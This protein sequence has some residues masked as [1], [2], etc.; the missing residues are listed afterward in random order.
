MY[1]YAFLACNYGVV[2]GWLLLVFAPHWKWTNRLVHSGLVPVLFGLVYGAILFTVSDGSPDGSFATL[3]GVQAIFT[4]R[5][6]TAAGWIH[7]LVFDLFIGAWQVRDAKRLKIP[8][9]AVVPCLVITL[10]VGPV[11]LL[12]Y[13]ALRGAMRKRWLLLETDPE[14][15]QPG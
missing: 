4:S 14:P 12:S 13:I 1:E 15:Q 3:D 11:G 5:Q 10:F 6:A 2:L 9:L 8:H 7:Y